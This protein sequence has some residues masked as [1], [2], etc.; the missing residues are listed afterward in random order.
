[1][2]IMGSFVQSD[3]G[4]GGKLNFCAVAYASV[5]GDSLTMVNPSLYHLCFRHLIK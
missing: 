4:G 5:V 3:G 1:M 2:S